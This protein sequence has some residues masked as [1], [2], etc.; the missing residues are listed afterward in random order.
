MSN[1]KVDVNSLLGKKVA[2]ALIHRQSDDLA[3]IYGVFSES[4]GDLI[5]DCDGSFKITMDEELLSRL[6]PNTNKTPEDDED[7]VLPLLV[8]DI[9][10][11]TNMEGYSPM[12]VKWPY[13]EGR[14]TS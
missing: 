3:V 11:G 2:L 1:D 6:K 14:E 13:H 7:F 9:P 5:V 8:G 12:G 10:D 4:D